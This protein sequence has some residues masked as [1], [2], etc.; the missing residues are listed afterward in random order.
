MKIIEHTIFSVP[1]FFKFS[2]WNIHNPQNYK[3]SSADNIF[4]SIYNKHY[5]AVLFGIHSRIRP[6]Q[7]LPKNIYSL[8]FRMALTLTIGR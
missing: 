7:L 4:P 3:D 1:S 8:F 2:K 6:H 5:I